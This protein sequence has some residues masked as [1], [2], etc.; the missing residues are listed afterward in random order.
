MPRFG[1]PVIRA[2]EL[3]ET[4]STRICSK[5]KQGCTRPQRTE[6]VLREVRKLGIDMDCP[7]SPNKDDHERGFLLDIVWWKNTE[8]MDI[9]LAVESELGKDKEV[10]HDF[11]KL[12]IVKA[13]QKLMIYETNHHEKESANMRNRI[14]EY[15]RKFTHHI[16]GEQ[17]VLLEFAVA[18]QMVYAYRCNVNKNGRLGKVE[19]VR[20]L[21]APIQWQKSLSQAS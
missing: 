5:L 17:Y 19:F 10:W 21:E 14:K 16:Y 11:G 6:A 3:A 20:I 8:L 7:V 2:E 9:A 18:E 13:P 12:M 15:M 4:L 1:V